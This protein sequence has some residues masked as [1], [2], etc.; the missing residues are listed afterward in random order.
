MIVNNM[1]DQRHQI[2][3]Q[4]NN[5]ENDQTYEIVDSVFRHYGDLGNIEFNESS[6]TLNISDRLISLDPINKAY[7]GNR[8]IVLHQLADD[9]TG[10]SGNAGARIGN[11]LSRMQ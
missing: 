6:H 11:G 10:A 3:N 8:G 5:E 2:G 1:L 4:C 7:V 9:F